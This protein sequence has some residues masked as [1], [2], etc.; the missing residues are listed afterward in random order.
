MDSDLPVIRY[1]AFLE[2]I[3]S[4]G[5]LVVDVNQLAYAFHTFSLRNECV[6]LPT[7]DVTFVSPNTDARSL[8]GGVERLV[9]AVLG[10]VVRAH[11]MS[12]DELKR[13]LPE[14]SKAQEFEIKPGLV[15]RVE[16]VSALI[17][18][19]VRDHNHAH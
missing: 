17:D 13:T 4:D 1:I 14:H 16:D 8:D 9:D 5:K 10:V 11:V 19:A 2:G 12:I 7:G 18:Q 15:R 6:Y 3:A